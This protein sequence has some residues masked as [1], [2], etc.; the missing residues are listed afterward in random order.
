VDKNAASAKSEL[1]IVE[2]VLAQEQKRASELNQVINDPENGYR[3]RLRK[4]REIR[5]MCEEELKHYR[6]IVE[7]QQKEQK[8]VEQSLN[9]EQER[10]KYNL[11]E[12]DRFKGW[13]SKERDDV[14]AKK[15]KIMEL[16]NTLNAETARA[17]RTEA[18]AQQKFHQVAH[19]WSLCLFHSL[20]HSLFHCLTFSSLSLSV[21]C[22]S[23]LLSLSLFH[24]LPSL[25]LA[26]GISSKEPKTP[27]FQLM[28]I[29]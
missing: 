3:E 28:L 5:R 18:D 23:I 24:T 8:G 2:H 12:I 14:A 26:V 29:L 10:R 25:V 7:H 9:E 20:F 17:I 11:G 27:R 13:L 4:E 22:L 6:K 1:K 16:E 21:C 15:R 19:R